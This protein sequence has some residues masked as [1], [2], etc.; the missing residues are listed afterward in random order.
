MRWPLKEMKKQFRLKV[1]LVG[2]YGSGK[3]SIYRRFSTGGF[4]SEEEDFEE[5]IDFCEVT[6]SLSAENAVCKVSLFDT[7]GMVCYAA[8]LRCSLFFLK[9]FSF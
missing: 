7:A 3:T 8:S 2:D 1:A 6:V 9:C 5:E 4:S